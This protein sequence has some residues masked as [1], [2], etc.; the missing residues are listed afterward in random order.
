MVARAGSEVVELQL[1]A[2]AGKAV[3]SRKAQ[4]IVALGAHAYLMER[5]A[6]HRD[7]A[8]YVRLFIGAGD[9]RRPVGQGDVQRMYARGV[10]QALRVLRRGDRLRQ[11]DGQG[12]KER[13]ENGC[14]GAQ[15]VD[16]F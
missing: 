2:G 5:L 12:R 7:G 11:Q 13:G 1:Q 6:V 16:A 4:G 15:G 9:E 10:E 8:G 14:G 3:F